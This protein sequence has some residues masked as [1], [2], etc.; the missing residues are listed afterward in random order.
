MKEMTRNLAVLLLSLLY[1]ASN[2]RI[3]VSER[4]QI[5]ICTSLY[6]WIDCTFTRNPDL[7]SSHMGLFILGPFSIPTEHFAL[8]WNCQQSADGSLSPNPDF[9][10]QYEF[11]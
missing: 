8:L 7:Q 3:L 11:V 6:N 5:M 4:C 9:F 1:L 10:H 2:V